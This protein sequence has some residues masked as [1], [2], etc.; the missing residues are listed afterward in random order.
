MPFVQGE[1]REDFRFIQ[2]G[3]TMEP[4]V[5]TVL[6]LTFPSVQ[7]APLGITDLTFPGIDEGAVVQSHESAKGA[8]GVKGVKG[9]KGAKADGESKSA[10][11]L[12]HIHGW[13]K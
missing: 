10:G 8:K 2:Y 3:N 5:E 12:S 1:F 4:A 7:R 9:A 6:D 11:V 13:F